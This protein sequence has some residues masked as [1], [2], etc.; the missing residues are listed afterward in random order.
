[1]KKNKHHSVEFKRNLASFCLQANDAFIPIKNHK[2]S[3]I[4]GKSVISDISNPERMKYI[5]FIREQF[6]C[7]K[8]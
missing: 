2:V 3:F 8:H 7:L 4:F 1:M 5:V 6:K